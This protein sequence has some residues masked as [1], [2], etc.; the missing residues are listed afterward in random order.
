MQSSLPR[1]F[2]PADQMGVERMTKHGANPPPTRGSER[3]GSHALIT[4]AATKPDETFMGYGRER[5]EDR[6]KSLAMLSR[7]AKRMSADD[8]LIRLQ[9]AN[10]GARRHAVA[11]S[12]A[13]SD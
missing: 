2:I 3:L 13:E 9:A 7:R 12:H 11:A 4:G 6:E 10:Y 1:G 5:P 8:A